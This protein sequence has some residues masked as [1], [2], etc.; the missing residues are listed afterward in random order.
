MSITLQDIYERLTQLEQKLE[1]LLPDLADDPSALPGYALHT[2]KRIEHYISSSGNP[3][4]KAKTT[5]GYIIYLRQ[6]HQDML[7][8]AGLW[9]RLCKMRVGDECQ[10]SL[11]IATV[12]EG[13][14]LKPVAITGHIY[15][16]LEIEPPGNR[17]IDEYE[18][19][20]DEYEDDYDSD[21]VIVAD[22]YHQFELDLLRSLVKSTDYVVLDTETTDLDGYPVSVAVISPDGEVLLNRLIKPPVA[23]SAGAAAVHGITN[24]MVANAVAFGDPS[25][26]DELLDILSGT[27]VVGW[28]INFD[29]GIL[30]RAAR[31]YD[32]RQLV[33]TLDNLKFVD[34]MAPYS[35]VIARE[36]SEYH[37]N[38]RWQKLTHAA[39]YYGVSTEGAHGALAD[40]KMTLAVLK[41]MVQ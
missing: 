30:M 34:V 3:T 39:A 28:N 21:G 25:C 37:G 14:F 6:A 35:N 13:D 16:P 26:T 11:Q 38:Y 40:A 29:R 1:K 27:T 18:D 22:N 41:A 10:A 20:E 15:V 5:E 33:A 2:V 19:Y 24:E 9:D 4:W 36:W 12:P 32:K 31:Y 8:E 23:I 17:G 7:K